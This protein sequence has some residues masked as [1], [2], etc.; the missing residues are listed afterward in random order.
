MRVDQ[1]SV[2]RMPVGQ[3]QQI[4]LPMKK[5]AGAAR[6]LHHAIPTEHFDLIPSQ[7]G[8]YLMMYKLRKRLGQILDSGSCGE[9]VWGRA[10]FPPFPQLLL[11][12]NFFFE[13]TQFSSGA[14]CLTVNLRPMTC[15]PCAITCH[16]HKQ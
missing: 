7:M 12:A 5:P 10:S 1:L 14:P 9:E 6:F 11:Y 2:H 8:I 3:L 15:L 13:S 4:S 16:E